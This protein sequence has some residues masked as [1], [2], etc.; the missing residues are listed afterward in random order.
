MWE[1]VDESRWNLLLSPLRCNSM[2]GNCVLV[3]TRNMSIARMIGARDSVHLSCLEDNYFWPFFKVCAFG[4]E[5]HEGHPDLQNIGQ[6]IAKKLKGCPLAARSVGALLR[7]NLGDSYWN[8]ILDSVEW[9]SLKSSDGIMPALML[10][11]QHLPFYLQRCFSYCSLFR[12]GSKLYGSDLVYIWMAQG[13]IA[14]STDGK[15]LEDVGA[16]YLNELVDYG[17]LNKLAGYGF[18]QQDGCFFVMHDLMHDLAQM[19]SSRECHIIDGRQSREILPTIR[20]LSIDTSFAYIGTVNP[21]LSYPMTHRTFEK[22]NSND[23]FEKELVNFGKLLKVERLSTLMLFGSYGPGCA[24]IVNHVFGKAKALRALILSI[25]A[26]STDPFLFNFADFI[27]LRYL[28]IYSQR[29]PYHK[30]MPEC[31]SRLYHLQT[32]DVENW[33]F[34]CNLPKGL[35]NLVNLRHF[36]VSERLHAKVNRIGKLTFL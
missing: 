22:L 31:F 34:L 29:P 27:H 17:F 13:F 24:K 12:K 11:Y 5:N 28:R 36:I 4:D 26:D 35:N 19:V 2:N 18:I 33:K 9:R 30:Q 6:K 23:N 7:K 3:T 16:E 8:G 21:T 15:R 20:H 32:L 25:G 1:D 10:S 14:S